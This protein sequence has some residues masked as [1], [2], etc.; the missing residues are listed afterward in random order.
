MPLLRRRFIVRRRTWG[1]PLPLCALPPWLRAT[2]LRFR[3][4]LAP[5]RP[6]ALSVRG[7]NGALACVHRL[8]LSLR[9]VV[10]ACAAS[11]ILRLPSLAFTGLVRWQFVVAWR[12]A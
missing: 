2:P 9:L 10:L 5:V 1:S 3:P 12:A 8:R 11:F 7:W 4:G 6:L